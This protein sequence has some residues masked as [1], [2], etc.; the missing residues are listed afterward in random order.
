M[1]KF[2]LTKEV[3][4]IENVRSVLNY[5]NQ[6]RELTRETI[7]GVA[8]ITGQDNDNDFLTMSK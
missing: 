5:K 7:L 2:Y 1:M 6:A 4:L 3:S 8:P